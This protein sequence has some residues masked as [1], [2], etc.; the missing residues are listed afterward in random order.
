MEW[1]GWLIWWGLVLGA[2]WQAGR[3]WGAGTAIGS[4][5]GLYL[6]SLLPFGPFLT[7]GLAIAVGARAEA[8]QRHAMTVWSP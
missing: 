7:A 3:A 4:L 2:S 8:A 1:I 6:L 5:L